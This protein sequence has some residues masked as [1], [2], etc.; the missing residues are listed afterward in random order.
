MILMLSFVAGFSGFSGDRV[1]QTAPVGRERERKEI[2]VQCEQP[3]AGN[4]PQHDSCSSDEGE[5]EETE[6]SRER[7]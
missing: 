5:G 1:R 7:N 4:F 3:R 2:R 6:R